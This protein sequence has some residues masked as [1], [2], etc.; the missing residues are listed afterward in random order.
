MK[1]DKA[2]P[3][4]LKGKMLEMNIMAGF[5]CIF[6]SDKTKKTKIKIA[7]STVFKVYV[8]GA[9]VYF[10][11][12]RTAHGFAR[13]KILN[14][15]EYLI[16]G[17]NILSVEAC[18]YNVNGYGQ[19]N[20]PSYI[21][22]EIL[23]NNVVV[24]F[25]DTF[26]KNFSAY[27]L[28]QKTQK[29]QR[30]SY[31]RSFAEAY[32]LNSSSNDWQKF[33]STTPKFLLEDAPTRKFLD[34]TAPTAD[35]SL[36]QS[37][38]LIETGNLE[39]LENPAPLFRDRA[40]AKISNE[41]LGFPIDNLT[42]LLT[43]MLHH[44][45]PVVGQKQN[46]SDDQSASIKTMQYALWKIKKNFSGFITFTIHIAKT[47]KLAITF[48]EI[49]TDDKIKFTRLGSCNIAYYELEPGEYCIESFEP[50]TFQFLQ[51]NIL[52]GDAIVRNV[53]IRHVRCKETNR[54]SLKSNDRDMELLFETGIETFRQN[55]VDIF[56]DCPSRERAG[57]L[58]DSYYTGRA[59]KDLTG[60]SLI[61]KAF[62]E[63]YAVAEGFKH[64]P[65][66]MVAMCFPADNYNGNFIPNWSLWM[67]LEIEEY[68]NRTGDIALVFQLQKKVEGLFQYFETLVNELG[69]L[70]NLKGWI[71]VEWS[72]ANKFVDGINYPSN[73]LYAAALE[74]ADRLYKKPEY[75]EKAKNIR[76][77]IVSNS[78]NGKF[79]R[80]QS[81]RVDGQIKH[82][83]N[84]SETC[85][86]FAF[87]FGL[88]TPQ[89]HAELWAV[90]TNS[91]GPDRVKN[92]LYPEI[93]PS[94]AFIGN[95]MRMDLLGKNGL[96]EKQL[97]EIKKYYLFMA[98]E[99]GTF[100]ENDNR[101]ASLNHGFASCI[102]HFF[103]R[104]IIGIKVNDQIKQITWRLQA[105]PDKSFQL[106]LPIGD[107]ITKF[108]VEF[109]NNKII[110]S[111]SIPSNYRVEIIEHPIY[112]SQVINIL[113]G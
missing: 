69:L 94:N 48:D 36:E 12:D 72:M 102:C 43:D 16:S 75:T 39:N 21:Q 19:I 50:Y 92:K 111:Y 107:A 74:C 82:T 52:E 101:G 57:W 54:V 13:V 96:I 58:C 59:E 62:L 2:K 73:M 47:T 108:S 33:D 46:R 17:S 14:I 15:S 76:S 95:L 90:L 22:A 1:F 97:E 42:F 103:V 99:T 87:Y 53:G 68:L 31:Q 29:V 105:L 41:I 100:W 93:H 3:V 6:D 10:G 79:F 20:E 66:G 85:Q 77:Q 78:F 84:Y 67:I 110:Y 44:I 9:F 28:T 91:F 80:D 5:K 61:E 113:N 8:N 71:F 56:M 55:A 106:T 86:Y 34:C 81:L 38:K 35:F 65:Q 104:D 98:N 45:K 23:E 30:Y 109:K 112:T 70:E 4:W 64:L 51:F 27:H 40:I 32:N 18:G 63:N 24:K 11:P 25:T 60:K 49:L 26:N 83:E 37:E 7:G 89:T 88:A